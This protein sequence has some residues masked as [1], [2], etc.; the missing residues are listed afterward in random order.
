MICFGIKYICLAENIIVDLVRS[1]Y[2]THTTRTYYSVYSNIF[3]AGVWRIL[4]GATGV[5][6][7]RCLCMGVGCNMFQKRMS[8]FRFGLFYA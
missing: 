6:L 2:K 1:E 7:R 4:A 8:K 3:A 5:M